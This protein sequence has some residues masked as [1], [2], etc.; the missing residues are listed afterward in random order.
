[1]FLSRDA[2]PFFFPDEN[3]AATPPMPWGSP[4]MRYFSGTPFMISP[5]RACRTLREKGQYSGKGFCYVH[6]AFRPSDIE[7][8]KKTP[9]RYQRH[10]QSECTPDVVNLSDHVGS[11]SYIKSTIEAAAAGTKWAVGTEVNF[12]N[13]LRAIIPTSS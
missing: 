9:R 13:C 10:R 4:T 5:I 11:T 3:L 1:M 2:I 7:E 8:I 12:V 6:V